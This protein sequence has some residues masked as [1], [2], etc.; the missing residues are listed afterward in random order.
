MQ[1]YLLR[2]GIAQG[3]EEPGCP[4]DPDRDLTARGIRRTV[5][6]LEGLRVLGVEVAETWTSPYLRCRHTAE[7]AAKTLRTPAPQVEEL[8][9]PGRSI[10]RAF[11]AIASRPTPSVLIC[12]HAPDLDRL[13]A[14]ALVGEDALITSMKKAAC[15]LITL[16]APPQPGGVLRWLL[17]PAVLRRLGGAED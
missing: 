4:P 3:R 7:L 9:A 11:A 16:E 15:A 10:E 17:E 12:G 1:L 2:H 5:S 8:L 14:Y 6:A 13:A